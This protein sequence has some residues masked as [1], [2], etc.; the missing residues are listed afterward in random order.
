VSKSIQKPPGCAI[1][2]SEVSLHYE[3][4]KA[5]VRNSQRM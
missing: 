1:A 2:H 5:M 3:M 4:Y